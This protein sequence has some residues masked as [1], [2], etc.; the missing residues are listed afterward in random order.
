MRYC[1]WSR[2]TDYALERLVQ[3][4]GGRNWRLV[5]ESLNR[6]FPGVLRTPCQCS[7]Y[8]NRVCRHEI[9]KG[10]WTPDE[11]QQLVHALMQQTEPRKWSQIARLVPGRTDVQVRHRVMKSIPWLIRQGVP[12]ETLE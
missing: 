3:E 7:Q 5:A 9:N 11:N 2:D 10:Q 1:M 12:T 4:F 8:W 6:L